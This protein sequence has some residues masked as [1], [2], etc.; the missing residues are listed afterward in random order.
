MATDRRRRR[1]DG[2]SGPVQLGELL[3]EASRELAPPT[4]LAAVQAAWDE[5]AGPVA[6]AQAEPVSERDGIITVSCRSA[7]WAQE[8]EMLQDVLV[9]KLRAA[10]APQSIAGLRFTALPPAR[11]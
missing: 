11:R 2:P 8:L 5:A 1:D 4:L 9:A 10:V 7:V 6:A 3:A